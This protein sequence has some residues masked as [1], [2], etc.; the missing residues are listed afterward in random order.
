M[1]MVNLYLQ[2]D[3]GHFSYVYE[4]NMTMDVYHKLVKDIGEFF[5]IIDKAAPVFMPEWIVVSD[6]MNGEK[7]KAIKAVRE[8][9]GIGLKEA[10]DKVDEVEHHPLNTLSIQVNPNMDETRMKMAVSL[11]KHCFKNVELK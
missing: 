9:T 1:P 11:L 8:I 3:D 7:I 4:G 5:Q 6:L 2:N 10:K